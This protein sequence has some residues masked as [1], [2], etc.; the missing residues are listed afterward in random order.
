MGRGELLQ[1]AREVAQDADLAAPEFLY[2]REWL[3]LDQVLAQAVASSVWI[4]SVLD[5]QPN[6]A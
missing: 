2:A 4:K 5:T 6:C 1:V 3:E